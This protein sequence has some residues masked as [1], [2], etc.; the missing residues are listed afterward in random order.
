MI[1]LPLLLALTPPLLAQEV[2]DPEALVAEALASHPSLAAMDAGIDALE[3]RAAVSGAWAD[4]KVM[5]GYSN[6]PLQGLGLGAHPMAGLQLELQ[7]RLP[8]SGVPGAREALAEARIDDADLARRQQAERLAL[9]LRGAYWRLAA[10]RQDRALTE[11]HIALLDEL[12]AVV[13]ARYETGAA[14]QSA[15]LELELRRARLADTLG[16]RQRDDADLLATV[17]QA[18]QRAPSAFVYTPATTPTAARAGDAEAWLDQ[19]RL[20][21]PALA[22]LEAQARTARLEAELATASGRPDPTLW[23]GY[24]LR[25]VETDM[26]P[27]T[28][29]VSLGVSV[30]VPM[31]SRRVAGGERAAAEHRAKALDARRDAT[32]DLLAAQL[33][34][35]EAAWIR[36]D[37]LLARTRDQL[38]PAASRTLD[39]V[40]NDYRVG[41]AGFDA[42]VRAELELLDLERAAIAAAATTQ[43]QH[44][45]VLALTGRGAARTEP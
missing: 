26:D 1:A 7:Q 38:I 15:L 37:S 31:A 45:A 41:R 20:S 43:L 4:P 28:D 36:A 9:E 33:A 42:L 23:A 5:L 8:I 22:E 2:S 39:A 44:A 17:N 32:E 25:T 11:R 19:A 27:G 21:S 24:R 10:V 30:P 6:V 18:L 40:L 16:D 14:P 13:R 12:L 29:L 3:A 35:A 34:S